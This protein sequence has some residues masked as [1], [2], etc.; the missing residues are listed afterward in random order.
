LIQDDFGLIFGRSFRVSPNK[1]AV[2]KK[3]SGSLGETKKT[4]NPKGLNDLIFGVCKKGVGE[5]MV[6]RELFLG[7]DLVSADA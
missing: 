5:L 3:K 4:S 1:F 7:R 2:P 6:G